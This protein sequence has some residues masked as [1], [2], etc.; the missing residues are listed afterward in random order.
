MRV[1]FAI[2]FAALSVPASPAPKPE[3]APFAALKPQAAW[4]LGKAADWVEPTDDA[5]SGE[6]IWVGSKEPSAVHRIDPATNK[7]VA[8]VAL[9]GI[10]CAGL[11][12]GF[13]SLWV[14][15]CAKLNAVAEIDL[16]TS[17]LVGVLPV[18][19]AAAEGGI[20]AGGDSVWVVTDAKG[21]LSRI[22]PANGRVRQTIKIPPG[23]YNPIYSDGTVWVSGHDTGVV[24]KID[25]ASGIV[26]EEVT[27]GK[28]PRFLTAGGGSVWVLLQA[29]G[30]IVRIDPHGPPNK[31]P[32]RI[33]AGLAGPGGD[34]KF[35]A[36]KV[37][38]T[39]TGV[40]LTRIDA[41]TGRIEKQW[42]GPGGDSLAYA[43]DSIW[44]T[45]YRKGTVA[46]Y[47]MAALNIP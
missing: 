46:R 28:E 13:G 1:A 32:V 5:A 14:P 19:P 2:V 22:D 34:I 8:T 30:E 18:R 35:G 44:L 16:K 39:V 6:A 42:T 31:S 7:I 21:V 45:D 37:W 15:L 43:F 11:A 25:P 9:P 40:P 24:T 3:Q 29:T 4:H 47:P 27:V 20:A 23:S 17:K 41:G 12:H 36:G 10:P 33:A 26:F 38:A